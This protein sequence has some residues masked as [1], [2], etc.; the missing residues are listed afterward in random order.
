M[1]PTRVSRSRIAI[2][3]PTYFDSPLFRVFDARGHADIPTGR[4]SHFRVGKLSDQGLQR[5]RDDS[6]RRVSIDDDLT[7]EMRCGGR[8][9]GPFSSTLRDTEEFQTQRGLSRAES[10]VARKG[11]C[12]RSSSMS[13]YSADACR[14]GERNFGHRSRNE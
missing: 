5:V 3:Y 6:D 1:L 11:R 12:G 4:Q 13:A 8:L 7:C 2:S 14:R 10:L 9:R